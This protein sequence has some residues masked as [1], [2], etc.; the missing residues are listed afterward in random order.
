MQEVKD[1]APHIARKLFGEGT[2]ADAKGM[3]LADFRHYLR[4]MW[5]D[6]GFRGRLRERVGD[7]RFLE[8]AADVQ[9]LPKPRFH[10]RSDG[11]TTVMFRDPL[12]GLPPATPED[13]L[14][15]ERALGEEVD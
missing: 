15:V 8:L 6:K 12:E 3:Q 11:Q 10:D 4:T 7:R 1:D 9:G 2:R 14:G 13:L 5:A